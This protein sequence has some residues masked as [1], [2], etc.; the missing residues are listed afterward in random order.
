MKKVLMVILVVI[1]VLGIVGCTT[2]TT[3]NDAVK[4]DAI[5]TQDENLEEIVVAEKWKAL[6]V[7]AAY[8]FE[9]GGTGK[10]LSGDY[11]FFLEWSLSGDKLTVKGS[12]IGENQTIEY[13]LTKE[14]DIYI[15]KTRNDKI[16]FAQE[17]S[18]DK[19]LEVYN[20]EEVK[21]IVYY[22]EAATLPTVDSVTDASLSGNN[23]STV[24]GEKENIEYRYG[25]ADDKNVS[26]YVE[27]LKQNGFAVNETGDNAYEIIE[28]KYVIATFTVENENMTMNII[29]AEKRVMSNA[30]AIKIELGQKITTDEYEFTLNNIELTYE[31]KPA[32]T[33]R[34]Y[35]SYPAEKGKIYIHVDGELYNTSK[36][37]MCIGDLFVPHADFDNGFAYDGFAIID[38][39]DNGFDYVSS[40]IACT[41]LETC[42][43]HGLIECPDK[44]EDSDAPLY[45]TFSL[46]D[47][48]TY[49]YDIRK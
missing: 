49:R 48:K 37:D 28:N 24:N 16:I 39:G 4:T 45:V 18:Y 3:N 11:T 32:N 26:E 21:Y 46:A 5:Q 35:T 2:P 30:D 44:I 38:D 25:N 34:F 12:F 14:N 42:H 47:G 41:P 10:Y 40:Y 22:D 8:E 17:S 36:R 15:I 7:D 19:A 13:I 9:K 33:S 31:L 29:P 43:Y 1:M 20:I 27:Y 23:K 6:G